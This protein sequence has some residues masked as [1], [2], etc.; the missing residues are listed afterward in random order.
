MLQHKPLDAYEPP[1]MLVCFSRIWQMSNAFLVASLARSL[2]LST[3]CKMG[4]DTASECSMLAWQT[5][6]QSGYF[7]T[8]SVVC[9]H[10]TP[11]CHPW[12]QQ[13]HSPLHS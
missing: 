11:C 12:L 5:Q 2:P 13:I 6:Q 8:R 3:A 4:Q 1:T 10:L 7:S 9:R